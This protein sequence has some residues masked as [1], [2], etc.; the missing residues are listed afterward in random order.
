MSEINKEQGRASLKLQIDCEL[1]SVFARVMAQK[2][3]IT[4]DDIAKYADELHP[5]WVKFVPAFWRKM[6]AQG[7]IVKTDKFILSQRTSQPLPVWAVKCKQPKK[8]FPVYG[9]R[10]VCASKERN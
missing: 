6:A 8:A 10:K 3:E 5:Q 7:L 2:S 4:G 1:L 9:T